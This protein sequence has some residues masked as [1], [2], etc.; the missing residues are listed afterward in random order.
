MAER[1]DVLLLLRRV[2]RDILRESCTCHPLAPCLRCGRVAGDQSRLYDLADA[3]ERWRTAHMAYHART[4]PSNTVRI[5]AL[6]ARSAML[7]L[8]LGEVPE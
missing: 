2:A 5:E 1:I 8:I 7:D 6:R 4:E 3:M